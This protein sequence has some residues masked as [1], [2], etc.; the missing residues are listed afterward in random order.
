VLATSFRGGLAK[1][2]NDTTDLPLV[3]RFFLG[4]RSTVRGY[5]QD[6]LGPKG[7]DG[8]PTGGNSFLMENFEIRTYL[9]RGI[10]LVAFL[11]GGNVWTDV[12]SIK[13]RDFKFTTGLGLRYNTPV[14]PIRIDYG[15]KLDKE[16]GESSGE[17]H[18]SIGHAF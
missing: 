11:D 13:L 14:G 18:F 3:E 15:Y 17:V 10:G 2:Y 1:G 12:E 9:G 7:S 5:E 6:T 4:G 8:D 16:K